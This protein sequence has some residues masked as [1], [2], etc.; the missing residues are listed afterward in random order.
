MTKPRIPVS[1]VTELMS[2]ALGD[3][4]ANE[5]VL[6]ACKELGFD[7]TAG[8]TAQQGE[9]VLQRIAREKGLVGITARFAISRFHLRLAAELE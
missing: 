7:A 5:W 4:T 2:Q 9:L 6:R 3:K 1:K 8:L